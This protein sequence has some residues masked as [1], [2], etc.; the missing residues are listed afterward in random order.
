[1]TI[2]PKRGVGG[3]P[4]KRT[5]PVIDDAAPAVEQPTRSIGRVKVESFDDA[6]APP[7]PAAPTASADPGTPVNAASR[8]VNP[9]KQFPM[10]F[11]LL[12]R[13]LF[14]RGEVP[15]HWQVIAAQEAR[16]D[17]L[18]WDVEFTVVDNR[19]NGVV[20]RCVEVQAGKL[21]RISDR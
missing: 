17:E 15:E 8:A 12:M 1:M 19:T 9:R 13:D 11:D 20:R 14:Q 5:L 3:P 18:N 21:S 4:A 7:P 10:H 2:P 16:L 6:K